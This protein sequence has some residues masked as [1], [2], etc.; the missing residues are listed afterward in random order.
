MRRVAMVLSE[1]LMDCGINKP[2]SM[3][4]LQDKQ[5]IVGNITALS[6]SK[7]KGRIGSAAEWLLCSIY[8]VII[9]YLEEG[10]N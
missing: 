7:I 2:V 8:Q 4:R 1:L 10:S 3:I 6:D 9:I 5:C